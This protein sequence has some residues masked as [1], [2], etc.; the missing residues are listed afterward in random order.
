MYQKLYI[1]NVL[2]ADHSLAKTLLTDE[3]LKAIQ[4]KRFSTIIL[5]TPWSPFWPPELVK[6]YIVQGKGLQYPG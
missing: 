6:H 1:R 3:I 4:E 2:F 5:D